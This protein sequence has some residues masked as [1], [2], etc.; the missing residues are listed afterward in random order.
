[1]IGEGVKFLRPGK[2]MKVFFADDT[3]AR[4]SFASRIIEIKGGQMK[5]EGPMEEVDTSILKAGKAISIGFMQEY[6][7]KK[8]LP[9]IDTEIL[10]LVPGFPSVITSSLAT[11]NFRFEQRREKFR[12]DVVLRVRYKKE[13]GIEKARWSADMSEGGMSLTGF[14]P[15]E[16]KEADRLDLT[17]FIP[18]DERPLSVIGE[19]VRVSPGMSVGVRFAGMSDEN[20]LRLARFAMELEQLMRKA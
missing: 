12:Y 19:V 2:R 3:G 1:M 20:K 9:M 17:V 11:G 7:H 14:D 6:S 16:V 4:D 18:S 5:V 8:G 13:G 15:G 10:S